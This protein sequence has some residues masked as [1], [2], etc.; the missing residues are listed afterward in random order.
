MAIR[1]TRL[2]RIAFTVFFS[3][4]IAAASPA[5]VTL[6]PATGKSDPIPWL[7]KET[8][9]D[10]PVDKA[11]TFGV[12]PNGVRYAVRRN[13]VPPGQVSI[14]VGIDAGSMMERDDELGFA[15]YIEH[16]SF[17]GSKF[18]AD[19]EAKRV[20]QR[21]GASFGSDTNA[22]T[23]PTQTI[24]KL[25]LPNAT[26]A[27]LNESLKIL[28]GMMMGPSISQAEVD[29]E[30]RTVLAEGREQT[31]PD[32][33]VGDATRALFFAGQRLA[34]RPPIGT[35]DTIGK[36]TPAAL[37]AFHDRWYRPDKAIIVISGDEAPAEFERLIQLYFSDWDGK[38]VITADPDFG[39]PKTG[40]P[41]SV[42]VSESGLPTIINVA[43]L[44]P[45]KRKDD[46]VKMNQG[47]M[48]ESLATELINRRLEQRAR[49]GGSFLSAQVS[50]QDISR[51]VDG[52][53]VTIVPIGQDWKAALAD[54][55][56]VIADAQTTPPSKS[57]IAREAGE[58]TASLDVSV[59]TEKVEPGARQADS[60]VEAVNIRETVASASVARD[61]FTGLKDQIGP[62]DILAATKKLFEGTGPRA[63]LTSP[64]ML[65][66]GEK[67]IDAALAA[68]VKIQTRM[69]DQAPVSFDQLPKL[70]P[71]GTIVTRSTIPEFDVEQIELS[72]GV[73]LMLRPFSGD[74]GRVFV[75]ARFGNGFQ[76]L[77]KSRLTPAW[78]ASSA[79]VASGIGNLRQDALDRMTSGRQI[80]FGFEVSDDAFAFSGATR[81][82]DVKEQ[83]QLMA[84][85]FA[86]PGWDPAPITRLRAAVIA[87][88]NSTD[89]SPAAILSRDLA[90]LL[91]GGDQRWAAPGKADA[92]ALTPDAFRKFWEP[93]LATGPIELSI[94][95]DF[96]TNAVIEAATATFGALPRRLPAKRL[97]GSDT[98]SGPIASKMITLTHKGPIDQAVAVVAW[99]TGGGLTKVTDSRM[100]DVLAAIFN[101]RLFE[102]FREAE[103]ASYSSN[104]SSDWPEGLKSG[105]SFSALAQMKP[106]TVA[107]FFAV[108]Q[109]I[110]DDLIAK[111]VSADELS[112]AAD[113][114]RQRLLRNSSG[115]PFWLS[116]LSG[117]SRDPARVN[118]LR[119]LPADLRSATPA[120]IQALAKQYFVKEKAFTLKVVPQKK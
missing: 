20:W 106:D 43:T 118:A 65:I 97:N 2:Q 60:I 71:P 26:A 14:R 58:Y 45:W 35:P 120:T 89:S 86:A 46:T 57:E 116:N 103:G 87:G 30:R 62:D 32:Q 9:S 115:S 109:A 90:V 105:G 113:P 18:V 53:F 42:F 72:N 27:G 119:Q 101:D 5:P 40:G 117:G 56:A 75:S 31:G 102:Q 22:V 28:S 51:S 47:R 96:D 84:A 64:F 70:G 100:L 94:Y 52:T 78:A 17:R 74:A 55:R 110:A 23:S 15:H 92:N 24:Y 7:Y 107:R 83:L 85:K 112:R 91:H 11:W 77:P 104:V 37:R 19:G 8:N 1:T 114:I 93:L 36:A 99:P 80:G 66:D 79:M 34:V 54:V 16:L 33:K 29:A 68:P 6:T 95:G 39:M 108:A 21:L 111:P 12:L 41:T 82:S 63:L 48:V 88:A 49:A 4:G 76:A 13:G 73:T 69:A 98:A 3:F 81:K 10:I 67:Q 44:R 25:D 59:E 50:R 61:V 38:S